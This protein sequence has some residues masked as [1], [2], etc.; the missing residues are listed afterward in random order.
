M[1][2]QTA[3]WK[4]V[5]NRSCYNAVIWLTPNLSSIIKHD[6]LSTSANALRSCLMHE[7]FNVSFEDI[8]KVKKKCT[9]KEIMLYQIAINL[10]KVINC[11]KPLSFEQVTILNQIICGRRQLRF[12]I[13]RDF[14]GR[15]GI[16]MM[17]NKCHYIY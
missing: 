8:H 5:E 17:A 9:P 16:N 1:N 15:I 6:L 11:D 4:P 7:G 14:N 13:L 12:E 2:S 3:V 10:H